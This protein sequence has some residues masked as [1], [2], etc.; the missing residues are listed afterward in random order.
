MSFSHVVS[1]PYPTAAQAG[2]ALPQILAKLRGE[3]VPLSCLAHC[4]YVAAGFALSMLL[5][6]PQPMLAGDVASAGLQEQYAEVL[7]Q[8]GSIKAM[9][10]LSV[11]AF[12]WDT[13]FA[14]LLSLFK[15]WFKKP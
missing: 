13:V 10:D 8:A 1:F 2:E 5:P 15:E 3:D 4:G 9:D 14:I 7:K 11:G 12:P 6:H